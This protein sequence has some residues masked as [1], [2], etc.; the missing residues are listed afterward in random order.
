MALLIAAPLTCSAQELAISESVRTRFAAVAGHPEVK[1]A[2]E[3]IREDEAR[4]LQD[5]KE[6]VGIEA[7]PF[8]EEARAAEFRKRIAALGFNNAR[9]DAEGNV[10]AVREGSGRGPKLVIGAHLDTVFPQGTDLT[11]TERDGKLYA[12]GIGDNTRGLAE[13]LSL[14]RAMQ[15]SGI[16]TVGDILFLGSVGEEG[17]GN[18]RGVKALFRDNTDL[19]GFVS[20]DGAEPSSII[21]RAVGS[22]RYRVIFKGPGGHSFGAFGRPSAIHAMGRAIAKIGNVQPPR[23][24]RSTFTVGT[25][26][27]GTSVNAIAAEAAMEIDMRSWDKAALLQIEADILKAI[28]DGIAEENA[29]WKSSAITAD[30]KLV[31]ERPAGEQPLDSPMVQAAV[32]GVRAVGL[33]PLFGEGSSNANLPISLGIPAITVGRGGRGENAHSLKESFDPKNA[34]LAVQR[35]LLMTLALVGIEGVS[36]PLLEKRR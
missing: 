27:G 13:L 25:V 21:V 22:H 6:L 34:Y 35:M 11:L 8:K 4:T 19:D 7:P 26:S 30:I 1:K 24:P 9:I 17:L 33:K 18:L 3:L 20:L 28:K 10:I 16:K 29:R 23:S 15:A 2:L 32:L 5:Q 36:E 14:I 31:G 12:P